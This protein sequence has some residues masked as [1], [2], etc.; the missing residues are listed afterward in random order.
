M[1]PQ[2][3]V[4]IALNVQRPTPWVDAC[5]CGHPATGPLSKVRLLALRNDSR[6]H[7]VEGE[8]S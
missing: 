2:R 8:T 1:Q 3:T 4:L 5:A 6:P 7:N